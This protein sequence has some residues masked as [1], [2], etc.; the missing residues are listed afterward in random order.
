[1]P[2]FSSPKEGNPSKQAAAVTPGMGVVGA[3][4]LGVTTLFAENRVTELADPAYV[5]F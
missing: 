4:G 5:W 3:V 1:M 2:S